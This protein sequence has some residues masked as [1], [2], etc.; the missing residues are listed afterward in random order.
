MEKIAEFSKVSLDQYL[1]DCMA[2]YNFELDQDIS[3]D[4]IM[5][6]LAADWN[7][8]QLPC[9]STKGSAGYDFFIP[10]DIVISA[11]PKIVFTGIRC[12]ID[13]G[14]V[15]MCVPRSGLGFKRGLRLR[16]TVGVI[17]SD[18][19]NA[20]NEGHIAACVSSDSITELKSGDRFMQG[21]FVPFGIT[22]DD[23]AD[24]ERSGGFGSTG[25]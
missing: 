19:Y 18:Y 8:I 11:H 17:D 5:S 14:W 21:I 3:K 15:L 22:V 1:T 6:K 7:N 9:R 16:N 13:P 20:L 25:I 24:S 4:D 12:R 10:K 2:P 23:E